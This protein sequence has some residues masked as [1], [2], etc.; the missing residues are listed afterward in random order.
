MKFK[1]QKPAFEILRKKWTARHRNVQN[2]FWDNHGEALKQVALGSLGGLM[3]ISPNLGQLPKPNL[4]AS[5]DDV[6]EG[7]D[8]NVLLAQQLSETVPKEVR[9][10]DKEEE[11]NI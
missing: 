10:L 1:S 11:K 5:R 4:I 2:K 6:M 9:P 8:K 7:F 3:L